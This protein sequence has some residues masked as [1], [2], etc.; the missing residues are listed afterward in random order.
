MQM[1]RKFIE[2]K[3][4]D[5][6]K[7]IK[8]TTFSYRHIVMVWKRINE[9]FHFFKYGNVVAKFHYHNC[10]EKEIIDLQGNA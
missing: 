10:Y 8:I 6:T 5:Y 7:M 2:G 3:L 1:F 9:N 4:I